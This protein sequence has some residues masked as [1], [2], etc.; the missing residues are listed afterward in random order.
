MDFIFEPILCVN[1]AL[2]MNISTKLF[3]P[4][5]KKICDGKKKTKK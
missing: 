2:N 1:I 3:E 4:F 5:K